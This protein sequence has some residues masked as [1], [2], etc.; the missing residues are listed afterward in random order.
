MPLLPD[1]TLDGKALD[2]L[3]TVKKVSAKSVAELLQR[4]VS[5][6]DLA[7][8]EDPVRGGWHA[9]LEHLLT[10]LTRGAGPVKKVLPNLP[11]QLR[12]ALAGA[13][14]RH[15]LA[16]CADVGEVL[17]P[18]QRQHLVDP[19]SGAGV[20]Y[21]IDESDD[22]RVH[23][24]TSEPGTSKIA[25][26][27][28]QFEDEA[29]ARLAAVGWVTEKLAEGYAVP[30]PA[31][32]DVAFETL[33]EAR[34]HAAAWR[35]DGG[36]LL[37]ALEDELVRL[38]A[39]LEIVDRISMAGA[40]SLSFSPDGSLLAVAT[41]EA[42]V[43]LAAASGEQRFSLPATESKGKVFCW[44]PDGALL[45]VLLQ[46][47]M[48]HTIDLADGSV[49]AT[50]RLASIR[51][52]LG[53]DNSGALL[54]LGGGS[55]A[56]LLEPRD[57]SLICS[58]PVVGNGEV[59]V[60]PGVP[61]AGL[62][63]ST[64]DAVFFQEL[65]SD[66]R[67]FADTRTQMRLRAVVGDGRCPGEET[68]V[69]EFHGTSDDGRQI[70]FS[71]STEENATRLLLIYDRALGRCVVATSLGVSPAYIRQALISPDRRL[72]LVRT[73]AHV[74]VMHLDPG[75]CDDLPGTCLTQ[76]D[77]PAMFFDP[78]YEAPYVSPPASSPSDTERR[79]HRDWLQEGAAAV[80]P[81]GVSSWTT[82]EG[83]APARPEVSSGVRGRIETAWS[84]ADVPRLLAELDEAERSE[85]WEVVDEMWAQQMAT[86][87]RAFRSDVALQLRRAAMM[88]RSADS[89]IV[90]RVCKD[91]TILDVNI[92]EELADF[93]WEDDVFAYDVFEQ[94]LKRP[95]YD[96]RENL[97]AVLKWAGYDGV[98]GLC[99]HLE[100]RAKDFDVEG[101]PAVLF[102]RPI[103][104][105][106]WFFG[107]NT[108]VNEGYLQVAQILILL[109]TVDGL[110]DSDFEYV[111]GSMA[112]DDLLGYS[113][114]M[115]EALDTYAP[116]KLRVDLTA[117]RAAEQVWSREQLPAVMRVIVDE[118][119]EDETDWEA[120][121]SK[122][123]GKWGTEYEMQEL[124]SALGAYSAAYGAF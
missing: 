117:L 100:K 57:H 112:V 115:R 17:L 6:E 52:A 31:R 49:L 92:E 37:L 10:R 23:V 114:E 8:L 56:L 81:S 120:F 96:N 71:G 116:K 104:G 60:I 2:Q 82:V 108:V 113:N 94:C 84:K 67:A 91:S 64:A 19:Q 66:G 87:T 119:S 63:S 85:F 77:V 5:T 61:L 97:E 29:A 93:E 110:S 26:T 118:G 65:S 70:L 24:A 15:D 74:L 73:D 83:G 51:D 50:T 48:L 21:E 101:L 55:Q 102:V 45:H 72:L 38:D 124:L 75:R 11:M 62:W 16:T 22:R 9:G 42:V 105:K 30:V 25:S 7:G 109:T 98:D 122:I 107:G 4:I 90:P 95:D 46:Q 106:K 40:R 3:L 27:A 43:V 39:S 111:G 123:Q 14:L 59:G 88:L 33:M 36:E 86:C 99:A 78:R 79:S 89:F 80:T 69:G 18:G 20:V 12:T 47:A 53:V 32:M 44:S 58:G 13:L 121:R 28:H 35:P 76:T 54:L 41:N 34:S 1:I 103:G 68:M